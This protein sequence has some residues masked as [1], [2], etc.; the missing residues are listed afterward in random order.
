MKKILLYTILA[1]AGF[2]LSSCSRDEGPESGIDFN[3]PYVPVTA[4]YPVGAFFRNPGSGGQDATRYDRMN[5]VWNDE[6]LIPAPHL[7]LEQGNYAVDQNPDKLTDE[8]VGYL[9]NDVDWCINGGIDF[10]IMPA[11]RAKQNVAAPDCLD[12]DINLYDIIRGQIGSDVAGSGKRVDLKTLKFVATVNIEDPLCQSSW[13]I[14]DN[15]GNQLNTTTKTLSNTTLLDNNNDIV[16][17]ILNED[18]S[19]AALYTRT[20]VFAEFFKSLDRFFKDPHYYRVD[21]TRPLVVLQNAHKLYTSDCKQFYTNLKEAVKTATGEDIFIVAQQEGCW[22]P[23]ARGEYFFQGVDAI[24]NKNMYNQS[25]WSRSVEYPGMIKLNW[26]YNRQYYLSHWNIDWIPTG[27]PAFNGYVD[28]GNVDKPVVKHDK[29]TFATMCNVMRSQAGN[30]R[31]MFIDSYNDI[32]Y[33]SFL[34]PTKKNEEYPDGFGTDMLDV[35]KSNF[36]K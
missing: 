16:S 24:T 14:Y 35:V 18:G 17:C 22:N 19:I 5:Q 25:N 11:V 26:E 10:W 30:C 32:Q 4:D 9:Q 28:N 31:I 8:M 6:D 12:G 13:K 7:D 21:G 23:P 29:E 36:K 2:A 3:V 15:D 20:E 34:V 1:V 27:A 33:C